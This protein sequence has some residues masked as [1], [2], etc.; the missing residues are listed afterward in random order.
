M[1]SVHK[2]IAQVTAESKLKKKRGIARYSIL[3]GNEQL[4]ATKY[5][6]YLPSEE[7]LRAEIETQK[8]LFYLQQNAKN[9]EL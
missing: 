5:K 8:R 9:E 7:E 4:F 3:N 1:K 6:T 2:K